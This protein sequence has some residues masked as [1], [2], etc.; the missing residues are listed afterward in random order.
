[1][2]KFIYALG[3]TAKSEKPQKSRFIVRI[4]EEQ[5]GFQKM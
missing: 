3:M 5:S 4:S 2:L 1:V